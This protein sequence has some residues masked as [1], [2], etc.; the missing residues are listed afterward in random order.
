[1]AY[2]HFNPHP[3]TEGDATH[4]A[5]ITAKCNFNPHPHTEGDKMAFAA[6]GFE[7]VISIHTLTLR[8][9]IIGVSH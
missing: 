6:A 9:T 5:T 3:H 7:L 2:E 1:M 4:T 8:V